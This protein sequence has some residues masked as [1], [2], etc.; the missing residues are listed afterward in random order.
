MTEIILLDA[1][2][3]SGFKHMILGYFNVVGANRSARTGQSIR[4]ATQLIKVAVG[5][6]LGKRPK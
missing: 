3:A 1:S 6:A 4:N 2:A 5:T